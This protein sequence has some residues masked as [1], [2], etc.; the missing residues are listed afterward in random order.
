[1]IVPVSKGRGSTSGTREWID[2]LNFILGRTADNRL[3]VD[4]SEL[5]QLSHADLD[6]VARRVNAMQVQMNK[7]SKVAACIGL[8][9][10]CA[11][12]AFANWQNTILLIVIF[13]TIGFV[14]VVV[15]WW[16]CKDI[17][18]LYY[19]LT[20]VMAG[21][22]DFRAITAYGSFA[23]QFFGRFKPQIFSDLRRLL[24]LYKSTDAVEHESKILRALE[25]LVKD[26]ATDKELLSDICD[27]YAR[28]GGARQIL[29]LRK[30]ARHVRNFME[31]CHAIAEIEARLASESR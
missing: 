8:L 17:V 11:A 12:M 2:E 1:M 9:G 16:R 20:G 3:S 5:S 23:Y 22:N 6:R 21:C 4:S 28:R 15:T 10:M 27:L 26:Q 30:H 18:D 24:A 29:V 31:R 19:G 14:Y 25:T 7:G 13:A